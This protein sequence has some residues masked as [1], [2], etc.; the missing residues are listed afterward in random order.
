[1]G[2]A[3]MEEESQSWQIHGEKRRR[4][5]GVSSGLDEEEEE[6]CEEGVESTAFRDSSVANPLL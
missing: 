5:D 4:L 3:T 6:Y 2:G 1:M